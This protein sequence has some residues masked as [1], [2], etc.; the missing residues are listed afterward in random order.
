MNLTIKR[1]FR[2][3]ISIEVRSNSEVLVRAPKFVPNKY[4]K[5]FIAKHHSWINT[6]LSSIEK[7][8]YYR[9]IFK[10]ERGHYIYFLGERYAIIKVDESNKPILISDKK[11]LIL[12]SNMD[13]ERNNLIL[14]FKKS[15]K[16]YLSQRI[17]ELS[18]ELKLPFNKLRIT[19]AKTRWGSCSYQN[20][21]NLSYRLMMLPKNVIDYVIIHEL[22][23]TKIKNHSKDFWTELASYDSDYKQSITWINHHRRDFPF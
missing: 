22:V 7:N 6:K 2:K 4:I 23:H 20:N 17:Q 3:T 9:N 14:F 21:I 1:S 11:C 13:I 16:E 12:N 19:S 18:L 10:T 15:A 8:P 5:Q